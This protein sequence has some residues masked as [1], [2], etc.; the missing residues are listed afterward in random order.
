[1]RFYLFIL[2]SFLCYSKGE[3]KPTEPTA[4][5]V[6]HTIFYENGNPNQRGYLINGEK[7]G[8]WDI[9]GE[10]GEPLGF[11]YYSGGIPVYHSLKESRHLK[12]SKN[13]KSTKIG[14]YLKRKKHGIWEISKNRKLKIRYLYS[15]GKLI[16]VSYFYPDGKLKYQRRFSSPLLFNIDPEIYKQLNVYFFRSKK[17]PKM[18]SLETLVFPY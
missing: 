2:L 16:A 8:R 5:K 3:E 11:T 9:F 7:F 6:K 14:D 10:D 18:I 13:K 15:E 12:T 4:D 17:T 1:M